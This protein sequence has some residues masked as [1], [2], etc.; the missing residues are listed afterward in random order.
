MFK[1]RATKRSFITA[2]IALLLC[3]ACASEPSQPE[4]SSPQP[5]AAASN[6]DCGASLL[7]VG[8]VISYQDVSGAW[9]IIGQVRNRS[10]EDVQI[11]S[12]C[13]VIE[14]PG[15]KDL[16]HWFLDTSVR[17][18]EAVPFRALIQNKLISRNST[19]RFSAR[20]EDHRVDGVGGANVK[21]ERL[22]GYR[23]FAT[24]D[25][26]PSKLNDG[27]L[28]FAGKIKNIGDQPTRNVRVLISLYDDKNNLIGVADGKPF[29]LTPL[30]PG[31]ETDFTATASRLF[32]EVA[33]TEIL[34]EGN[35]SGADEQ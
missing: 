30:M 11:A 20:P 31:E 14:E 22:V 19:F 34:V 8:G 3:V 27:R 5:A 15:K 23:Q 1:F 18:G 21:A 6:T 9:W 29:S 16:A 35:P 28:H 2:S 24:R 13:I 25:V 33:R 32:G 17:S 7:E 10:Y 26:V 4:T 12:L